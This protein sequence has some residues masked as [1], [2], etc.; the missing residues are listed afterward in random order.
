MLNDKERYHY[1][2]NQINNLPKSKMDRDKE[3]DVEINRGYEPHPT[4]L[5]IRFLTSGGYFHRAREL[6]QGIAVNT[7]THP[8][9]QTEYYLLWARI[10]LAERQPQEAMNLC[11][12]AIAIG[13]ERKEHYAA[14]AALLAGMAA[15]Q[16]NMV[17]KAR[18]YWNQALNI[19]G[20][21][22]VYIEN[23]HKIARLRISSL[24]ATRQQ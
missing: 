13:R 24:P 1:Y 18:E 19:H 16:L 6:A 10:L 2:L 20:Q 22:D 17:T 5:K 9:Y 12:K 23:I 14:D 7:L 3:A 8:A 21:E 15:M 4:L 11:N